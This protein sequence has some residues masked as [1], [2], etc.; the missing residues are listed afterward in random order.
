MQ[1]QSGPVG[2]GALRCPWGGDG[3]LRQ[4]IR[5]CGG[6]LRAMLR[7]LEDGAVERLSRISS[8]PRHPGSWPPISRDAFFTVLHRFRQV[9]LKRQLGSTM[10]KRLEVWAV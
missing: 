8:R 1:K 3:L 10:W 9:E 5:A 6:D 2:S 7:A 4:R